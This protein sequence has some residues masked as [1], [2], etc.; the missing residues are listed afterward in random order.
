MRIG[1]DAKRA[2]INNTG[3][4]NY[5][6]TLIKGLYEFEG[7]NNRFY[8]FT[9][10]IRRS[11]FYQSL[12]SSGKFSIN[13]PE[14]FINENFTGLWRT[15][16]IVD[17][18]KKH[19]IDI[20]H[21]LSNELPLNI[22]SS[23]IP[24]IVTIHDLIFKRFPKLYPYID[25]KIYDYKFKKACENASKIVAVSEA[26]KNDII[27]YYNIDPS[28]VEV[29]YQSCNK[30]FF[31]PL[32]TEKTKLIQQKYGLPQNFLLYVGTIEERKNLLTIIKALKQVKDIMLVVIGRETKYIKKVNE[33]IY[34]NKLNTRI[35][36]LGNIDNDELIHFY[37]LASI[38]IYPSIFEGFGIPVIEALLSK[39]PVITSNVSSLPEAAG[40]HSKLI[41]PTNVDELVNHI[42]TI[43]TDKYLQKTM[44]DNG[45]EHAQQFHP[46]LTSK[47]L[48]HLYHRVINK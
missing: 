14:G 42:N 8:L 27:E 36:F 40:A 32:N 9:P 24:S 39:T 38:F 20:Y 47:K 5:S 31:E 17:D 46:F 11:K 3:L 10:K 6:R 35:M 15:Y 44:I 4:G 33:Y 7:E 23:R 16:N 18:F 13:T 22:K 41:E 43:L 28:R 34:R 26:T 1:F 30:L 25:V 37:S 2:F 19:H 29:Q 48:L 21:G 12:R 45:W